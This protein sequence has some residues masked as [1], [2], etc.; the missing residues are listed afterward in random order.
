MTQHP[1]IDITTRRP[2]IPLSK[3]ATPHVEDPDDGIESGSGRLGGNIEK[4][5]GYPVPNN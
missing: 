5:F 1:T 4:G 3:A 2:T